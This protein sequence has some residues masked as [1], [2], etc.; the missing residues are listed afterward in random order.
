MV[1]AG[2]AIIL[3]ISYWI[4]FPVGPEAFYRIE[5]RKVEGRVRPV[6]RI[7]PTLDFF[8]V[9]VAGSAWGAMGLYLSRR[10]KQSAPTA[11]AGLLGCLAGFILA[12][13]WL[14]HLA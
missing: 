2:G 8:W 9:L 14:L 13:I 5:T 11:A 1:L 7:T 3:M 10:R 12:W 6:E 4:N